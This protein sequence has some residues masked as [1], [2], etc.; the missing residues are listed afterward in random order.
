[1]SSIPGPPPP[2]PELCIFHTVK[3]GNRTQVAQ[4][5]GEV[6]KYTVLWDTEMEFA[7]EGKREGGAAYGR[8]WKSGLAFT[9]YL[10]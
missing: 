1:M 7:A 4:W 5:F 9:G 8:A 2:A 3:Q 6:M 10:S